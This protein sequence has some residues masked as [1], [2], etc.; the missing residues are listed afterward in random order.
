[1]GGKGGL[2]G[3]GRGKGEYNVYVY[4]DSMMKPTKYFLKSWGGGVFKRV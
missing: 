2:T 1:M 3:K 4:K